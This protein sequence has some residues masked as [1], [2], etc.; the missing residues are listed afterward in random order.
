MATLKSKANIVYLFIIFLL[1]ACL[2]GLSYFAYEEHND[3]VA[4]STTLSKNEASLNSAKEEIDQLKQ[5]VEQLQTEINESPSFT[6]Q[7]KDNL[8]SQLQQA[9]SEKDALSKETTDLK[10]QIGTL[11]TQVTQLQSQVEQLKLEKRREE[12][13]KFIALDKVPQSTEGEQG[14]CYLTF[15]DGPSEN[16]LKVLDVLDAY[17]VKGTFFVVGS[18]KSQ[19]MT[20]IVNRGHAIG[21]H[22]ATHKYDEIYKDV[23]SYLEDFITISD[24]IYNT[25]GVRTNIMRFPGGSS[26]IISKKY[27]EGIMTDLTARM[28]EL[29]YAYFDWNVDSGDA[30]AASVPANVIVKNVLD[31]ARGKKSICVLMHDNGAKGTTVQALPQIIEGLKEM[32]YRFEALNATDF[33][34]HQ[35]VGN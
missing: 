14:V 22:T 23:N 15:D 6:K 5:T 8:T 12:L 17:E 11:Q 3:Y 18:T 2:A 31:G 29:G 26:N 19:Y 34:Y 25:T 21:I 4:T 9:L 32:C 35:P 16:T 33:G 1:V 28:Q 7:E 10:T 24:I 20:E 30:N 27:C 13:Q